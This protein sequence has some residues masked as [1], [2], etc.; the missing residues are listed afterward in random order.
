MALIA[1]YTTYG[2]TNFASSRCASLSM[3]CLFSLA[4]SPSPVFK[5]QVL[6]LRERF[7][8]YLLCD[9][10]AQIMSLVAVVQLFFA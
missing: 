8:F 7:S 5:D 10:L 6:A 2:I 9:A 3:R 4:S 1:V